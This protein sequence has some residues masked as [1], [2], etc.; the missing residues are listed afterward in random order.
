MRFTTAPLWAL[1]NTLPAGRSAGHAPASE[2]QAQLSTIAR[3]APLT[4]CTARGQHSVLDHHHLRA[5][6]VFATFHPFTDTKRPALQ[7]NCLQASCTHH[8]PKIGTPTTD[9]PQ[10]INGHGPTQ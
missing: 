3:L 6:L 10:C 7:L 1:N 2:R 8:Q 4:S 5:A 9:A